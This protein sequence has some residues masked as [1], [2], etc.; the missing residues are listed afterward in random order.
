MN[1]EMSAETY[2]VGSHF[3]ALNEPILMAVLDLRCLFFSFQ[4]FPFEPCDWYVGR[5]EVEKLGKA[6]L[7]FRK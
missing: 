4:P 3:E 1:V 6:G 7:W 5:Y 2:Q